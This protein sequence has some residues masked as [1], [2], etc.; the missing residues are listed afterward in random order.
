MASEQT[1]PAASGFKTSEGKMTLFA[2]VI[3]TALDATA[4]VLH[5][6]EDAG[7][8][9]P[10]FPTVLAVLGVF[11]QVASLAGYTKGRV[12]TKTALISA[13]APK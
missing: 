12:L 8:A 5:A 10:W 13:A 4:A 3:G 7:H 2:I 9:A 6:L 1:D 11:I